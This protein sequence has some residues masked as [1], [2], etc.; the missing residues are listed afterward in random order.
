MSNF[1][2]Q[3][4]ALALGKTEEELAAEG[5]DKNL[6]PHKVFKGDRP[7]IMLL[8]PECTPFYVGCLLSLYEHR[9]A[10]EGFIW[11]LNSFDQWGVELGKVLAKQ[12]RGYF[13]ARRNNDI[14]SSSQ[15]EKTFCGPT[16]R[17]LNQYMS[18]DP[19]SH[20]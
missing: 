2:A 5:V 19:K 3:P 18:E 9:T 14:P 7:S 6:I 1:F 8:L 15:L 12:V 11:G 20:H 17:L 16:R 13:Q 4:D 10:V